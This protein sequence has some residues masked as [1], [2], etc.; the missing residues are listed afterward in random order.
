MLYACWATATRANLVNDDLTHEM[1][2]AVCRRIIIAQSLYAGVPHFASS[3][4]T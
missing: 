2:A 1:K 4:H 3:T